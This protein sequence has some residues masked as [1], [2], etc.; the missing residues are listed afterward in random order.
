MYYCLLISFLLFT[1]SNVLSNDD[2]NIDSSLSSSPLEV[3]YTNGLAS[4]EANIIVFEFPFDLHG[5]DCGVPDCYTTILKFELTYTEPL[6]FPDEINI[7]ITETGC[8]VINDVVTFTHFQ[9]SESSTNYLNYFAKTESSNLI[10]IKNDKRKEYIYYF[11]NTNGEIIKVSELDSVF[12]NH[13]ENENN[14]LIPFR[15]SRLV[16]LDYED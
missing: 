7:K 4:I 16:T 6:L 13:N 15:I 8:N 1:F 10:I 11:P 5:I 9:L 12:K 2:I 3:A 14:N